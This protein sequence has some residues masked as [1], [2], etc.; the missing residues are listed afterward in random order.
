MMISKPGEEL[1][2]FYE[3]I[4][5]NCNLIHQRNEPTE[6]MNQLS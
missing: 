1:L 3:T 5:P 4:N 2:L 6:L